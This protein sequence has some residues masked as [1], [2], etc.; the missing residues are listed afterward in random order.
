MKAE[1]GIIFGRIILGLALLVLSSYLNDLCWVPFDSVENYRWDRT[2]IVSVYESSCE[3][4]FLACTYTGLKFFAVLFS[5][6]L[7][8]IGCFCGCL[9]WYDDEYFQWMH[10]VQNDFSIVVFDGHCQDFVYSILSFVYRISFWWSTSILLLDLTSGI[11]YI[12]LTN[13]RR[14]LL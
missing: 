5:R 3:F 6:F 4:I 9:F 8:F 12:C 13:V 2:L 11:F 10:E 1:K 14:C 7:E